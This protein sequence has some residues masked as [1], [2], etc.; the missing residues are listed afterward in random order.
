MKETADPCLLAPMAHELASGT[1]GC[2]LFN[3]N[4]SMRFPN[5]QI[6]NF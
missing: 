3:T 4:H 5:S 2:G 1:L 6:S